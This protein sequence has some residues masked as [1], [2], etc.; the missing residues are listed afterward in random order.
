M[1][2][3]VRSKQGQ[4]DFSLTQKPKECGKAQAFNCVAAS[5]SE[6]IIT[7]ESI[8]FYIH[9]SP[10]SGII[11]PMPGMLTPLSLFLKPG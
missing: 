7:T 6:I 4:S 5:G 2:S 10:V 1:I 11:F 8:G 9:A 3:K